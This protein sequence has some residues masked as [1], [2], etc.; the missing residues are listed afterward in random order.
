MICSVVV[1]SIVLV[2]ALLSIKD[3]AAT[4]QVLSK[5]ISG[6]REDVVGSYKSLMEK[7]MR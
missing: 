6:E 3:D 7:V 1:D 2:S 4:F 5:V